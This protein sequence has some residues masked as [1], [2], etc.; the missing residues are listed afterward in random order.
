MEIETKK[1]SRQRKRSTRGKRLLRKYLL[2]N[3]SD[4]QYGIAAI[5]YAIA[6]LHRTE[7]PVRCYILKLNLRIRSAIQKLF[8]SFRAHR[9]T[10]LSDVTS[11]RRENLFDKQI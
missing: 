2:V 7:C 8:V 9:F 5:C 3:F 10:Y 1:M 11:A 6:K 4:L